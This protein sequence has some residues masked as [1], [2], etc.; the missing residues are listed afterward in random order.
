MTS[1]L[2]ELWSAVAHVARERVAV[3]DRAVH[4]LASGAVDRRRR[5]AVAVEEA[6]KLVGSLD[7]YGRTGGSA[8]AARAAELLARD[9]PPLDEL[10]EVVRRLRDLVSGPGDHPRRRRPC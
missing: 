10:A 5:C 4:A 6:E 7:S 1:E 9:E 8:L 3:L 2:P